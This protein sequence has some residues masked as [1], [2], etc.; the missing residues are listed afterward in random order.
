MHSSR[1]GQAA[2][3]YL[4]TYGWAVVIILVVI[5][6]LMY[7]GVLNPNR[8]LQDSCDFGLQ[9]ECLDVQVGKDGTIILKMQNNF[10]DT[11]NLTDINSFDIIINK[12]DARYPFYPTSPENLSLA[13]GAQTTMV[14]SITDSAGNPAT[15]PPKEKVSINLKFSLVRDQPDSELYNISGKVFATVCDGIYDPVEQRINNC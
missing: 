8:F 7:F 3:E 12:N 1:K 2:I 4:M 5:G 15:F 9:L 11:I 10:G 13:N 6:A 14:F